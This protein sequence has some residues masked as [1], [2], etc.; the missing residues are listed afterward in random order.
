MLWSPF[1]SLFFPGTGAQSQQLFQMVGHIRIR[2]ALDQDVE[3]LLDQAFTTPQEKGDLARLH[4]LMCQL[5]TAG[6]RGEIVADRTGT[7]VHDLANLAHRFAFQ[8]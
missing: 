3:V 6:K 4:L 2:L 5:D 8:R 7:M 1:V